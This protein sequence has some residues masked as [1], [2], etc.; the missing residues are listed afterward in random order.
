MNAKALKTLDSKLGKWQLKLKHVSTKEDVK[1][2][3]RKRTKEIVATTFNKLGIV[4][5][6]DKKTELGYR[7]LS[8]SNSE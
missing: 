5:P 4:V 6:Y 7:P 2:L 8:M 1:E 3:Q